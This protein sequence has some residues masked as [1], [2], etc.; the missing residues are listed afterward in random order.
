MTIFEKVA[1]PTLAVCAIA[2]TLMVARREFFPPETGRAAPK[3]IN[4]WREY[5]AGNKYFGDRNAPVKIVEFS[6]YQC[7]FCAA[8]AKTAKTVFARF[9]G[10]VFY[11]LRST[12]N[13]VAHRHA[14]DAALAAECAAIQ[15]RFEQ[16][17]EFLFAHQD[18]IGLL[19]WREIATRTG[20]PKTEKFIACMKSPETAVWLTR[21]SLAADRLKVSGTPTLLVNNVLLPAGAQSADSLASAISKALEHSRR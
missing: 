12:P 7:P 17:H 21:D 11:V 8:S 13:S 19:D 20:V 2:M 10:K 4:D 5:A 1:T 16:F 3:D 15:G 18:S 6:D 9:P 14:R